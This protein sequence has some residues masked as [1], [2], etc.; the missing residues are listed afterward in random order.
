[1]HYLQWH[2]AA[3]TAATG[4][5]HWTRHL[6][7]VMTKACT[8]W[9]WKRN[10]RVD[11]FLERVPKRAPGARVRFGREGVTITIQ[12]HG[13]RVL[14]DALK[15]AGVEF[16][17]HGDPAPRHDPVVLAKRVQKRLEREGILRPG[18]PFTDYQYR[19]G[20]RAIER[21]SFHIWFPP[22][23]GKTRPAILWSLASAVK[24]PVVVVTRVA[25]LWTLAGEFTRVTTLEPHVWLPKSRRR[26][27]Y[28]DTATYLERMK[29][30]DK[31]PVIVTGWENLVYSLPDI[32]DL[33]GRY[34]L[35]M[36]EIHRVRSHS[37]WEA[38]LDEDGDLTFKKKENQAAAAMDLAKGANR[39]LALTGTPIPDRIRGLWAPLDL[40]DPWGWGKFYDW[41]DR[42]CA[43]HP[44]QFA[45][46]DTSGHSNLDELATRLEWVA[47][48]VPIEEMRTGLPGITRDV[49]VLDPNDL[50]QP[51]SGWKSELKRLAKLGEEGQ[52]EADLMY[53]AGMKRS[54]IADEVGEH[55]RA[56]LKVLVF[57]G[58][59]RDAEALAAAIEKAAPDAWVR[60][61]HGEDDAHRRAKLCDTYMARRE[62]AC[63]VATGDSIGESLNLQ[64]TDL[65]VMAM[66]PYTPAQV[67]Q[68]EA[69]S[70][71]LGQKRHTRILYP[72]ARKT[73]D[74][75]VADILLSKLP[76]VSRVT[77]DQEAAAIEKALRVH[78]S[79]AVIADRILAGLPDSWGDE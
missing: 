37:R 19:A 52:L 70:C 58:R 36:D 38:D 13:V 23:G 45:Y 61:T 69:R 35:I 30:S 66:L 55:L 6:A 11:A 4:T 2:A 51:T 12:D 22:G 26:K 53:A 18:V 47:D 59:R 60:W 9:I 15:G 39:R 31:V 5:W 71:R 3:A 27:K 17:L 49:R 74:E 41:A 28:E 62:A 10:A 32:R 76:V 40:V 24:F 57:T 44:G 63:V 42:Y 29:D 50:V 65:Q 34:S 33:V 78:D 79:D 72:I 56:G 21:V 75:R 20:G 7:D 43:A 1:M 68:W 8:F 73:A 25:A 67:L 64:D 48:T 77:G 16:E 14:Y 54:W 46:M